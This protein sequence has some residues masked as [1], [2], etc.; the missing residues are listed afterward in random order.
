MS[1]CRWSCDNSRSD[2]YVWHDVEGYWVIVVAD[3]KFRRGKDGG[4]IFK[5]PIPVG[6]PYAGKRFK[7][8]SRETCVLKLLMLRRC[9]YHVPQKAIKLLQQEMFSQK[10]LAKRR[11]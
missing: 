8:R 11:K 4:L 6:G 7:C 1:Y 10:R 2:V 9:G 5:D 3:L